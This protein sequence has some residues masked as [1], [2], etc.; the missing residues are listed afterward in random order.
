[1]AFCYDIGIVTPL[2]LILADIRSTHNVGSILRSADCFGVSEVL[3]A[4]YTPYPK[5]PGDKRLPHL[6]A[7]LTKAIYKTALGAEATMPMA[8]FKD[9]EAAIV[10]AKA[11]GY[12]VAALEQASGST[13]LPSFKPKLP[14]A[15][16]LGNEIS[17][18]ASKTLGQ[19]DIIIEIPQYG[20]KESLN[21][22]TAAA[23]ALYTLRTKA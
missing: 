11:K 12:L 20:K 15:L 2:L 10:Y 6:A 19:C 22:A 18:L 8:V 1:M 5:L 7:K 13:S 9:V 21:V 3:F 17:G 23:I 16:L 14:M 4:G